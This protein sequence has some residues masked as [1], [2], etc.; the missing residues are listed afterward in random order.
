LEGGPLC[1]FEQLIEFCVR[2]NQREPTGFRL[3]TLAL[4]RQV[5]HTLKASVKLLANANSD[6]YAEDS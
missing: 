6:D 5:L 4:P 2:R 3:N 1:W